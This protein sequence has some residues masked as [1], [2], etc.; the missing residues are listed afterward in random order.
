MCQCQRWLETKCGYS[1]GLLRQNVWQYHGYGINHIGRHGKGAFNNLQ[2][3]NYKID[4]T[5]YFCEPI[6][7]KWANKQGF[8]N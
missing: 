8:N 7:E 2:Y 1:R 5:I 3:G 6:F 4:L